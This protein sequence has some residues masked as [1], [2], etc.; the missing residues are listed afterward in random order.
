MVTRLLKLILILR[1]EETKQ[2]EK[3]KISRLLFQISSY[4]DIRYVDYFF[5]YQVISG[6]FGRSGR[7]VP[8]VL[9]LFCI[10][11]FLGWVFNI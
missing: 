3:G 4:I 1:E 6:D 10:L 2:S 7:D 9:I 11:Y 5:Q 8:N